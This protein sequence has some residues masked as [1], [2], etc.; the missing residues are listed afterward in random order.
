MCTFALRGRTIAFN[1]TQTVH[2]LLEPLENYL[3]RGVNSALV[4][5]RGWGEGVVLE[6]LENC[7]NRGVN[8]VLP[9]TLEHTTQHRKTPTR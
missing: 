5:P 8:A 1:N 2:M 3:N 6:P 7:L 9:P 4:R